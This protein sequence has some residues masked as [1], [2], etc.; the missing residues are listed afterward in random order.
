MLQHLGQFARRVPL[1]ARLVQLIRW[2]LITYGLTRSAAIE[3]A[4]Q[5]L[6]HLV[7]DDL[8]NTIDD[9]VEQ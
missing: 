5:A 1:Q 3:E 9:S 2:Y 6:E 8:S 4:K 7:E